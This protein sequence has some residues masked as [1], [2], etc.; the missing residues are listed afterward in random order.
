METK[1]TEYVIPQLEIHVHCAKK[2]LSVYRL[3]G[4][5]NLEMLLALTTEEDLADYHPQSPCPKRFHQISCREA[6]N[7][8]FVWA[9]SR[10]KVNT[11]RISDFQLGQPHQGDLQAQSKKTIS[12]EE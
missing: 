4:P 1:G 12:Q 11:S 5:V 2:Q 8:S 7:E 6:E 9:E 3:N 10:E